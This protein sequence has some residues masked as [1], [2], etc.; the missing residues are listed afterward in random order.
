MQISMAI[1]V[2]WI[3]WI[4]SEL[5]STPSFNMIMD[6]PLECVRLQWIRWIPSELLS[7]PSS[8]MGEIVLSISQIEHGLF[9]Q[10]LFVSNGYHQNYFLPRH[11]TWVS[12]TSSIRSVC[13]QWITSISRPLHIY[14]SSFRIKGRWI[15]ME[16][17][18][19]HWTTLT[20]PHSLDYPTDYSADSL[21]TAGAREIWIDQSAFSGREKF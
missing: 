14:T 19:Q 12:W 11:S 18:R 1:C 16:S 9:H 17:G 20:D 21:H 10:N 8:N 4:P 5:L 13:V 15:R 6:F 3:R 2:Q 7:T